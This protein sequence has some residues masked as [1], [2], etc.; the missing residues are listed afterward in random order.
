MK[1]LMA[2]HNISSTDEDVLYFQGAE[3]RLRRKVP[4]ML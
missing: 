1:R 3:R 2:I 4:R